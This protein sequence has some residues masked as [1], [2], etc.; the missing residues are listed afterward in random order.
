[1]PKLL[2]FAPCEKVIVGEDDHSISIVSLLDTINIPAPQGSIIP[3]EANA[4]I[5]W[6]IFTLWGREPQD[7][8]RQY[9][10]RIRL[11]KPEGQIAIELFVDFRVPND[12]HRNIV[13]ASGF[14]VGQ[15][16]DCILQLALI[17]DE[18]DTP[19]LELAEYPIKIV[20]AQAGDRF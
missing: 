19:P 9:T 7:A 1:M 6:S 2:V 10:Q 13:N 16:G 14:P 3:S 15:A 12:K 8:N 17:S 11:L 5:R 4:P 18:E 20:H